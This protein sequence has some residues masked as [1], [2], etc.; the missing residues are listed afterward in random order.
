M[1]HCAPAVL[2]Q[3]PHHKA[4]GQNISHIL[5]DLPYIHRNNLH[6]FRYY[7][8]LPWKHGGNGRVFPYHT[9]DADETMQ[10]RQLY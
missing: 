2:T 9:Y 3:S 4:S 10:S 1:D 8:Y 7:R 6:S 5:Y